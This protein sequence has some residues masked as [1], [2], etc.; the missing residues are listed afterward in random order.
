MKKKIWVVSRNIDEFETLRNIECRLLYS[1][2][3]KKFEEEGK[4]R[5]RKERRNDF[6]R[7]MVTW[8]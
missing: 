1:S 4:G 5:Y 3:R 8:L 6:D 7:R 2:K